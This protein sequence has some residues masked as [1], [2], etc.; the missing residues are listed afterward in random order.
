MVLD[1]RDYNHLLATDEEVLSRS[2]KFHALLSHPDP[3]VRARGQ[4]LFSAYNDSLAAKAKL[5]THE[6]LKM[7]G[8]APAKFAFFASE[9]LH[10]SR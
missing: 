6:Q 4:E 3:A 7:R 10:R 1:V 9:H 2:K 8:F 5:L